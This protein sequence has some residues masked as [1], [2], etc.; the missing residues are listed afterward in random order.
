M[1]RGVLGVLVMALAA[2]LGGAPLAEESAA[3]C[4]P[5]VSATFSNE[6]KVGGES[7]S[8]TV[9]LSANATTGAGD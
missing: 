7:R 8:A 5:A 9:T 4:K 6:T 1:A 2:V 3:A